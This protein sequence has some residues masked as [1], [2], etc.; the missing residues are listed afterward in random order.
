M[1][2]VMLFVEDQ[3]KNE[4]QFMST[5]F[6][7]E[8]IKNRAYVNVLGSELVMRY[9]NL[10][11]IE[12]FDL[13][14]LHSM[15]K[16]IETTDI[17]DIL[18]P[19]IHIDVRVV[20]NEKQIFVPISHSELGIEPD[21][22][23]VLKLDKGFEKFDMIGYFT[24]DKINKDNK[25]S[26]YYFVDKKELSNPE[27]FAQ[28]VEGFSGGKTRELSDEEI[29]RGRTLSVSLADH[30]LTLEEKRELFGLLLASNALRESVLEFDNFET[31]SYSVIP[32]IETVGEIKE[33]PMVEDEESSDSEKDMQDSNTED[34]ED[35]QETQE[36]ED[37]NNDILTSEDNL[38]ISQEPLIPDLSEAMADM[39]KEIAEGLEDTADLASDATGATIAGEAI[40]A[41]AATKGA[42]DLA[43]LAGELADSLPDLPLNE[44]ENLQNLSG[45]SPDFEMKKEEFDIARNFDTPKDLNDLDMVDE[46]VVQNFEQPEP[47]DFSGMETVETEDLHI[48]DYDSEHLTDFENTV[49]DDFNSDY[50]FDNNTDANAGIEEIN[51]ISDE[52]TDTSLQESETTYDEN[53]EQN[54]EDSIDEEVQNTYNFDLE[55]PEEEQVEDIDDTLI[56][57]PI[58]E[59]SQEEIEKYQQ[60]SEDITEEAPLEAYEK[61]E[62]EEA[63][64]WV[65]DV[66]YDNLEDA[67]IE[68]SEPE[69][70]EDFG[71]FVEQESEE[72]KEPSVIENSVVISDKNFEAGEIEIDINKPEEQ[73][74]G[75]S[76]HLG[77]LYNE[78]NDSMVGSSLL[79]GPGAL[80]R[81]SKGLGLGIIGIVVSLII[82]GIIGISLSKMMKKPTEETPQPITDTNVA[83]QA[84]D[85]DTLNVDE[86]NV[87]NMNNTS[88]IAPSAVEHKNQT[89]S[90]QV[91]APASNKTLAPTQFIEVRKLSWEAPDYVAADQTFRQYFQS[92]GKSLK[93]SLTSDLLLANEYIYSDQARVSINFGQDGS[94]K[95]AKILL[96]SGSQQV[97]KIVLQTV[98][99]TLK[100]LKA[101]HS[102]GKDSSTTV[103]LKIYF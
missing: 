27:K 4:A 47:I 74:L 24:P 60:E 59:N 6:V 80:N 85:P 76:E 77:N 20:F 14:N 49:K 100:V 11:G 12:T 61:N 94:F 53:Y 87:V 36:T 102:V 78:D 54:N 99:Q 88:P 37:I 67:E 16:I 66:D 103:I 40:A 69:I 96:S 55:Q 62:A 68:Q 42:M 5:N 95:D 64:E 81:P 84:Q 56:K 18:L 44:D 13:H 97:D 75:G 48:E 58:E 89:A 82:V 51:D 22:Y 9:L 73:F 33:V 45:F 41:G 70:N 91:K 29:L 30:D 15:S 3:D 57:E 92:A 50:V 86:G 101:P 90:D 79:N 10:E 43:A 72:Y 2:S 19:N 39:S 93:L 25:N 21:V 83:P 23:V 31:L 8:N 38:E 98:N 46:P 35:D 34:D 1:K 65:S 32:V 71:D 52:I 26:Q 7:D 28:F 63:Q 17:S